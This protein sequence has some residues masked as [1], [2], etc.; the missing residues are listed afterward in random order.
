MQ[1]ILNQ[2]QE[3]CGQSN[4]V[5]WAKCKNIQLLV[6][7]VWM[8]DKNEINNFICTNI[9]DQVSII[10]AKIILVSYLNNFYVHTDI[11][12]NH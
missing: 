11:K 8:E 7:Q 9:S 2:T 10:L 1:S 12:I 6:R 4:T 5:Y 3:T